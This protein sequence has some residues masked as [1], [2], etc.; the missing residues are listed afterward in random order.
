MHKIN[1][2]EQSYVAVIIFD[3]SCCFRCARNIGPPTS[4]PVS[5]RQGLLFKQYSLIF[6]RFR[7]CKLAEK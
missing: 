4:K 5:G 6:D 3:G 2:Y 7:H 1:F